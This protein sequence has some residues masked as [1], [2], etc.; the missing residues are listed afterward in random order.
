MARGAALLVLAALSGCATQVYY[1]DPP[2]IDLQPPADL[3]AR[4]RAFRSGDERVHGDPRAVA[5]ATLRRH[6]D[7]PWKADPYRPEEYELLRNDQW[8]HYVVRG[9][10]YPSGGVMRYRVKLR[11]HEEIWYPVQISRYKITTYA[12]P[13][14]DEHP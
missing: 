4:L 2:D 3:A 12:H 7:L 11:A 9:Y 6:L 10:T 14:L 1:L 13:A 5:D 8:G